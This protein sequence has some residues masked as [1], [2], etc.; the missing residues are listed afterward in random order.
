MA[1]TQCP[2]CKCAVKESDEFCSTCG[3]QLQVTRSG[4]VTFLNVLGGTCWAA[5]ALSLYLEQPWPAH[6]VLFLVGAI[7]LIAGHFLQVVEGIA[8][9]LRVIAALKSKEHVPVPPPAP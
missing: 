8:K 3:K 6:L 2:A 4:W 7:L 9:D 1:T 5:I